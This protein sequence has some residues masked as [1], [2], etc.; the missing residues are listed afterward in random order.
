MAHR[1]SAVFTANADWLVL[2][3]MAFNLTRAAAGLTEPN[4][5]TATTAT[6]CRK[7]IGVPSGRE[8]LPPGHL[9]TAHRVAV[10]DRLDGAVRLSQRPPPALVA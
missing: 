8:V 7:L 2:A 4:L 9:A 6:I 1:T 3:V 5:A 10:G